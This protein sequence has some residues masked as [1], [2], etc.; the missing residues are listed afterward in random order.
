MHSLTCG[1][2]EE[3]R[4]MLQPTVALTRSTMGGG[5]GWKLMLSELVAGPLL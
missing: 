3:A 5:S 1:G 4:L 2:V